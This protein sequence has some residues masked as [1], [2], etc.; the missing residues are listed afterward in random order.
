MESPFGNCSN[1]SLYQLRNINLTL[2]VTGGIGSLLA[3]LVVVVLTC[4]GAYKSIL[5]R[6]FMYGVL[7]TMIHE[8]THLASIEQ[9]FQYNHQAQV[10]AALGFLTNWTAWVVCDFHVCIV[11]YL[12][13]VVYSQLKGNN[14]FL[15]IARSPTLKRLTEVICIVLS[16]LLPLVILWVPFTNSMYGLDESW[17]W[18]KAFDKNCGMSDKL[19]FL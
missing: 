7:S 17:C 19:I 10:C 4:V 14:L 12:L 13:C 18:I 5:Q 3:A 8:A 11:G 9:R 16:V 15:K 1:F 2:S 6:L